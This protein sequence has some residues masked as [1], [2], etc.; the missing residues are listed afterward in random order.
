LP[1]GCNEN[2]YIRA[3]AVNVVGVGYGQE[4]STA[5]GYVS[6][7]GGIAVSNITGTGATVEATILSDGGCPVLERGVCFSIAPNATNGNPFFTVQ[8]G[9]G[10]GTFS[11]QLNLLIPEITYYCR[12]YVITTNGTYFG[13]EVTFTTDT[14]S[15]LYIGKPFAGGIIFD[16]DS[17]G[18]HGLVCAPSNQGIY[19]MGCVFTGVSTTS[20]A[21]GT[22]ATNTAS[23][24][25]GCTQRPIAASVCTDLVL[26]GY[27]DWFLPSLGELQLMYSRL[28][29]Q[30]QGA[31]D[32]DWYW[33][34]SLSGTLAIH[35][36]FHD[37][38]VCGHC[39]YYASLRVRAVRVF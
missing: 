9:I 5:N 6:K 8:S 18:Q 35:I 14:T 16:L 25:A 1:T 29:L 15:A 21:V 13:P 39:Y 26:N 11:C 38:S 24:L 30:G 3:F 10:I 23:I 17:T 31:F 4:V 33:S 28:K 2:F 7:F 36:G 22:G 34:S 20:N 37:G 32:N 12:A 19:P 27:S